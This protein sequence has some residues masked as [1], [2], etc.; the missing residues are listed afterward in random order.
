MAAE[1][2]GNNEIYNLGGG[3]PQ[4][5]NH[6]IDLLGGDVVQIPKRPGEPDCTW[7][8]ISKMRSHLAWKP[9][10]SL[11]KGVA[12]MLENLEYWRDAPVWDPASIE[13]AT[14]KWFASLPAVQ[15]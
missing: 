9:E 12:I 4:S 11:E 15:V 3:N 10:V 1:S 7:A 8:D 13:A 6:L 2:G 14:D 5:I